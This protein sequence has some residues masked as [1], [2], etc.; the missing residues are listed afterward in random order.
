MKYIATIILLLISTSITAQ[1]YGTEVSDASVQLNKIKEKSISTQ[2]IESDFTLEKRIA[3]MSNIEKS[4]GKFYYKRANSKICLDYINPKD[5]KIIISDTQ[6]TIV[7]AD[8]ASKMDVTRN[9]ALS[10]MKNMITACMTGNFII[11]GERSVTKYYDNEEYFTIV[12]QPSN[13]RVKRY[14]SEIALRFNKDDNTL[15]SMRFTEP[16]GNYSEY[17]YTNKKINVTID[18]YHFKQ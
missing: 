1:Q 2:T 6:F 4:N 16:N 13:K 18:E 8:K 9:P 14:M 17:K 11:L 15:F 12:I 3:M 7:T 5:N 10:Q